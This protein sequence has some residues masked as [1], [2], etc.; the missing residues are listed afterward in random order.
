ML[1]S[2]DFEQRSMSWMGVNNN[3]K[4]VCKSIER[5]LPGGMI[6]VIVQVTV[7]RV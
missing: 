4:E 2:Y 7:S 6:A 5:I 3:Q 1:F